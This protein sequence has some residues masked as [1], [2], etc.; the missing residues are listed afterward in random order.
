MAL[1]QI[2]FWQDIP[3]QI[4]AWDDFDEVKIPL[5]DRFIAKID[6]KAQVNGFSAADDYLAHWKW[7]KEHEMDG[8]PQDVAEKIKEEL[9][10]SFKR[11]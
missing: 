6:A 1:Y 5:D 11:T 4:K 9:E 7:G 3:S 2:L 8:D 10:A